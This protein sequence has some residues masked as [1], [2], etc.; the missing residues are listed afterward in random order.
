MHNKSHRSI[1]APPSFHTVSCMEFA[2]LWKS[3]STIN[4]HTL[5]WAV[6]M[7]KLESRVRNRMK[8]CVPFAWCS[9][10]CST[11]LLTRFA[12][13]HR[14]RPKSSEKTASNDGHLSHSH[15]LGPNMKSVPKRN[16]RSCF[17]DPYH[18]WKNNYIKQ[19]TPFH[20]HIHLQLISKLNSSTF[21]NSVIRTYSYSWKRNV[22]N[23]INGVM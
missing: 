19:F 17:H 2:F 10:I 16:S 6:I 14:S 13:S 21:W 18:S 9:W 22:F 15:K 5:E 8:I 3:I 1:F 20:F 11:C 12:C 7:N 4:P 23:G